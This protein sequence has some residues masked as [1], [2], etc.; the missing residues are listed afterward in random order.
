MA[1]LVIGRWILLLTLLAPCFV[2][3]QPPQATGTTEG[4]TAET[5]ESEAED[6]LAEGDLPATE[7]VDAPP[8]PPPPPDGLLPVMEIARLEYSPT[9]RPKPLLHGQVLLV[10][11]ASGFV[12]AHDA[13]TGAFQWKL[14][15]PGEE[16]FDPVVF[17]PVNPEEGPEAPFA[18]LLSES[19]GHV[20]VIDGRTGDIQRETRLPF[21]LALP[22]VRGPEQILFFAT[23]S[24]DILAYDIERREVVF[25]TATGATPL[26]LA[27]TETLL[28][29]SGDSQKLT[30]IDLPS[31][32]LRWSFVGRAAFHAPAAFGIDGER[33]Y[34]GDDTGEFF[35]LEASSGKIKFRWSTGAAIRSQALV[36]EKRV[37]VATFANAVYAYHATNG[38]EQWRASL[39]GRPATPPFR[40]NQRLMVATLDGILV[41]LNP[42]GGNVSQRYVAPGE[43][44]HAPSFYLATPSPQ[45]L[46]AELE[47]N[48]DEANADEDD[49]DEDDADEDDAPT[50]DVND[51]LSPPESS[52][53]DRLG[54]TPDE[55]EIVFDEDAAD[56]DS[57]EGVLLEEDEALPPREPMW[58]ERSRIAL[59]LRSGEVLL[60]MHQAPGA[61][62]SST[63]EEP[64]A[65]DEETPAP[66]E[67]PRLPTN[68][69]SPSVQNLCPF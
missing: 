15:L 20:L 38:G 45:E 36:E 63:T 10:V 7:D 33:I 64:L 37:Y 6:A 18:I 34:I 62:P 8:P 11:S 40:V 16:L 26:A 17:D 1:T 27:S 61:T 21:E 51:P 67:T 59:A 54:I 48:A 32:N 53:F 60:L 3:A 12:E 39:P 69:R 44:V 65:G 66:T 2:R 19:S 52:F 28:M 30:A 23:P 4:A 56:G 22:P 5:P 55:P 49:A 57:P 58:F 46:E 41:E 13:E 29:V 47:A 31:G 42:A 35:A 68:P 14:G 50:R 43:V 24:G 9:D 25:Q